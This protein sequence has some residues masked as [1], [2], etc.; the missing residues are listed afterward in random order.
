LFAEVPLERDSEYSGAELAAWLQEAGRRTR[1]QLPV[2][3]TSPIAPRRRG[4]QRSRLLV[5]LFVLA[6]AALGYGY[7]EVQVRIAQ[8]PVVMAFVAN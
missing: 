5:L 8:L 2:Q 4:Y 3:E 6:L 7:A 1:S